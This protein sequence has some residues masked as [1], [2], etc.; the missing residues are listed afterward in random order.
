MTEKTTD[1]DVAFIQTALAE[2]GYHPGPA[3]NIPGAATTASVRDFR[4]RHPV[5]AANFEAG[6]DLIFGG[7]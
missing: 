5:L 3:D 6:I 4:M 1:A 2:F 7:T